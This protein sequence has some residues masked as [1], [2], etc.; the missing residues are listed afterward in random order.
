LD[1]TSDFSRFT[2]PGGQKYKPFDL[3]VP[4]DFSSATFAAVAA[5]IAGSKVSLGG[6]DFSD[7]QGDK[8]I[9]DVLKTMGV[10]VEYDADQTIVHK[11]TQLKGQIVDLNS[12][13]DALPALAV[14]ACAAQGE[15]QFINVGQ[16]R[17]KETDRIAVMR[18]ELSKMGADI[19]EQPDGLIVRQSNLK[20]A[21]VN[22][23][24]DHRVVMALSL[25]AMIAQGE[26]VIDTAEAADVTYPSFV[27]DFSKI[28]ANITII[29]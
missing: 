6:L 25:A 24:D 26:T 16:A 29:E 9:F 5:A 11:C 28:G 14:L 17:I 3:T 23:H 15:T 10:Q 27:D 2:I 22:G 12:M 19:T 8:G 20:G 21:H 18:E 1:Y 7:P 13:P 4:S